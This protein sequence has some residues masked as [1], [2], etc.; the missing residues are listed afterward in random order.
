M[1]EIKSCD[2]CNY[3]T[4]TD[5]E[6]KEHKRRGLHRA[7]V[8]ATTYTCTS[9]GLEFKEEGYLQKHIENMHEKVTSNQEVNTKNVSF[10]AVFY[11]N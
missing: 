9:C 3:E 1:T 5:S 10:E 11:Y 4:E 6:L 2:L 7:E 8:E